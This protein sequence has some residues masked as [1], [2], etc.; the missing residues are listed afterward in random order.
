MLYKNKQDIINWVK[1][2]K[3]KNYTINKDLSVDVNDSVNLYD[4]CLKEIPVKFNIVKGTFYCNKNQ[5]TSTEFF[6][7]EVYGDFYCYINNFKNLDNFPKIVTS[8]I[9]IR[10]NPNLEN[11]IGLWNCD[12]RGK[13]ICCD[14]KWK[15][16]IECYLIS[17]NRLKETKIYVYQYN[18][19]WDNEYET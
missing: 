4:K 3:I 9:D 2:Y 5:L 8:F 13:I 14:E 6:P 19:S 17:I 16:E 18:R 11:I 1:Q 7:K 15:H 10:S 12:F